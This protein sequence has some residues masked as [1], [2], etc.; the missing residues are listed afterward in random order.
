[1]KRSCSTAVSSLEDCSPL[2]LVFSFRLINLS[3]NVLV[4]V[5]VILVRVT[6]TIVL[7]N[8]VFIF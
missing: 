5:V 3:F 2:N 8:E 6:L 4:E 1:M 7:V